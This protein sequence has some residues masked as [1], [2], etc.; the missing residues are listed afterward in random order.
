M[1]DRNGRRHRSVAAQEILTGRLRYADDVVRGMHIAALE[2]DEIQTPPGLRHELRDH[3]VNGDDAPRSRVAGEAMW[4]VEGAVQDIDRGARTTSGEV[5][6]ECIPRRASIPDIEG[7]LK[8][9][10][11]EDVPVHD[12][13]V[14]RLKV[15]F[16]RTGLRVLLR[17]LSKES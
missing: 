17:Q 13:G 16:D 10:I 1:H 11:A 7:L 8:F 3:V 5:T 12:R 9:R 15:D 4:Q 14:H 2:S 6:A